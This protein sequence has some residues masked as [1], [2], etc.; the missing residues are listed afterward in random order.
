MQ[1]C[2]LLHTIANKI[3][4]HLNGDCFFLCGVRASS[5]HEDTK[6]FSFYVLNESR[7]DLFRFS[8][9]DDCPNK[10]EFSNKRSYHLCL[11]LMRLHVV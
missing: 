1:N 8:E 2:D 7:V 9:K 11:G 5:S 6:E 4:I 3:S 10:G